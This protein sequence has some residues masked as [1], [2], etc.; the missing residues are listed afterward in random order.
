MKKSPL[1]AGK[2]G[3]AKKAAEMQK[4]LQSAQAVV[5]NLKNT[6]QQLRTENDGLRLFLNDCATRLLGS[7]EDQQAMRAE[8]GFTMEVNA[9]LSADLDAAEQRNELQA[10]TNTALRQKL[11]SAESDLWVAERK[12][13]MYKTKCT[14]LK[15]A[16]Q[17]THADIQNLTKENRKA[18]Q[19]LGAVASF[20]A[21][22]AVVLLGQ[23]IH[24]A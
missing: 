24:V 18:M 7:Q 22:T 17:E 11:R 20:A 1:M 6:V 13:S 4:A 5:P 23:L 19:Y 9:E 15:E 12:A 8:V 16:L 2:A 21:I 14:E 3:I 10:R